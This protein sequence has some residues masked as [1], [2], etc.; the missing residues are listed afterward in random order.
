MTVRRLPLFGLLLLA[1]C[2]SD[3][4]PAAPQP[5]TAVTASPPVAPPA[6]THKR[7]FVTDETFRGDLGG[8]EGADAK[9][10]TAA[11]GAS[12]GGTW[13]AWISDSSHDAVDRIAQVGPWVTLQGE[14]AFPTKE[15]IGLVHSLPVIGTPH[16][17]SPK[18]GESGLS[19][20][21]A[22][23]PRGMYTQTS[24]NEWASDNGSY[25]AGY[26]YFG[27]DGLASGGEICSERLNLLCLEQ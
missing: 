21:S 26:S 6:E 20:W 11:A 4:A 24:C 5:V 9:C 16:G 13:K 12:I 18:P 1:A 3:P 19:F 7:V 25:N 22:S 17:Y 15:S 10:T 23:D 27:E 14:A 2:S 8:I